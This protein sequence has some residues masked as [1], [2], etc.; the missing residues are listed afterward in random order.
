MLTLYGIGTMLGAGIYALIGK[1]V[2]NAGMLAPLAFLIAG[3]LAALTAASFAELSSRYP[4]SAGEATYVGRAFHRPSL[5]LLVGILIMASGIVSSGVMIV[6][7]VGYAEP[8]VAGPDFAI[9]AGLVL[10]ICALAIWGI[11]ES[12]F[13]IA[14]VTLVETGALVLIVALGTGVESAAALPYPQ[15]ADGA[16]FGLLTASVLAFYAFIGFEDMVNIA[17]EVKS[18]R[19][20]MPVAIFTALAITTTIYIAVTW[21][22]IR[23]TPLDALSA[24]EAPMALVF[25]SITQMPAQWM[26]IIAM[27][28]VANGALVQVV[29]ASRVLYGL[30]RQ[31]LLPALVGQV[32]GATRT[33]QFATLLVALLILAST[34]LDLAVLAKITS[35]LLL[36]V[37]TLVNIA[38]IRVR[39]RE[40]GTAAIFRAPRLM[41]WLGAT[42]SAAFAVVS[43]LSI[44][45]A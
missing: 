19:T 36:T 24:S 9:A 11:A 34:A 12:L 33:P 18:P 26:S 1:V 4:K 14:I 38:L 17:E 22:A 23:T 6:A 42:S 10:V 29:M 31:R 37:F 15:Q 3:A 2:A 32:S 40:D 7:F 8:F 13:A 21:T 39:D 20:A 5:T 44:A 41:P 43:L 28:A 27:L 25:N 45:F 30:S 35:F 16:F